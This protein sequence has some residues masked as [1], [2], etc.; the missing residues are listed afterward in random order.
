MY[1][2]YNI[3]TTCLPHD[4]RLCM[5]ISIPRRHRL[6]YRNMRAEKV[7]RFPRRHGVFERKTTYNEAFESYINTFARAGVFVVLIYTPIT[8]G[9]FYERNI[10]GRC[11]AENDRLS[12]RDLY[13]SRRPVSITTTA[14][15]L[16]II[17]VSI[18]P[19]RVDTP[20]RLVKSSGS[21]LRHRRS[22]IA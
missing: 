18:S 17:T 9:L 7:E 2:I 10:L 20:L 14:S 1:K 21:I 19:D 13:V 5:R 15:S 8:R 11:A 16:C 22:S 4:V 12:A 6:A 3:H